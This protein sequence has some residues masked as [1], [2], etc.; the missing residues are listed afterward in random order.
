MQRNFFRWFQSLLAIADREEKAVE[1][2]EKLQEREESLKEMKKELRFFVAQ[3]LR[4]TGSDK[5]PKIEGYAATFGTVASIGTFQERIQK[6]AFTRTLASDTDVVCLFNHEGMPL[7]RKSAGTLTLEEDELGLKFF[8]KLPDT[9]VAKDTYANLKAGNLRECS[10]GFYVNGPD[11]ESW[12]TLPDG[13]ALRTLLDV[14]LFDVSVVTSPAYSGTS[15]AARNIVPDD[16]EQR[17]SAATR[18]ANSDNLGVVPFSRCDSRSEDPFNSVDEA[19]GIIN[20]ADGSDEGRAADAPVKNKLKAAQGFLYV[21]NAGEKR[22]DFIGPHHTIVDGQLAHSQIGTLRCFR[23]LAT[24]KLDI[25]SEHRAAAKQH[26]DSEWNI[27]VGDN[28]ESEDAEQGT[29][30]E[31]NRVRLAE[32]KATL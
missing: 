26:L 32:A 31:R 4:A 28:G 27:W 21:K 17:M 2:K 25:P 10:F 7:G 13:T 16:L 6:G 22:S 9:T 15:A 1:A 8:C 12:S 23:D 18:A 14:S 30:I 11:G 5:S 20:W 29:E 24:G 19:N 3:E